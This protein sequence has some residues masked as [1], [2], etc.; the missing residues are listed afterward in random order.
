[1]AGAEFLLEFHN[2]ESILIIVRSH[3]IQKEVQENK[4]KS[5]KEQL[6]ELINLLPS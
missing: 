6:E 3:A 5:I 2:P 1:M 4:V